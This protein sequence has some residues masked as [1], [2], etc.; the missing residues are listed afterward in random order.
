MKKLYTLFVAALIAAVSAM[1]GNMQTVRSISELPGRASVPASEKADIQKMR[2]SA[3]DINA[4]AVRNADIRPMADD[5]ETWKSIGT[6]TFVEGPMDLF[7]N[8]NA[9]DKWEIE[10][11]ESE[12]T[13]GRYRFIPYNA[14]SPLAAQVGSAD[15]NYMIVNA[16]DP[17][18]VYTETM[19]VYSYYD[20][21]QLV[22]EGGWS[23]YSVYGTLVDGC[24]SFPAQS[25]ALYNGGW[26]IANVSGKFKIFL[27]GAEVTDYSVTIDAELCA[28]NAYSFMATAGESAASLVCVAYSGYMSVAVAGDTDYLSSIL[29]YGSEIQSGVK[30][31]LENNSTCKTVIAM[32]LDADGNVQDADAVNIFMCADDQD[33]WRALDGTASFTETFV[34]GPYGEDVSAYDLAIEE[35]VNTPGYY[36]L[37]NPYQSHPIYG[38]YAVAHSG[39]NHY[40]YVNATDPEA[41]YVEANPLG[42]D[43][44]YQGEAFGSSDAYTYISMGYTIDEIKSSGSVALGTQS[45][46]T[47]TFPSYS[48]FSV[49]RNDNREY[50]NGSVCTIVLPASAGI[51]GINADI[52]AD[53]PAEYYNLQGV[54]V[55]AENLVPGFY[56]VRQGSKATKVWRTK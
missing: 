39:H 16:Q 12:Q 29:V 54:K 40:L 8:V 30:Y 20:I 52:D 33:N 22:P 50:Y 18:K 9:G 4:D 31:S 26:Y 25:H 48:L 1:A 2:I 42:V 21:T 14:N 7:S 55:A 45:G 13:A 32:T 44:Y 10:I 43:P 5:T 41:V 19:S 35:N 49:F 23:S 17:E 6:G 38:T 15:S 47:I 37:V 28:D 34:S 53:A 36:R 11:F 27:P 51:D 24:I 56:V 3:D 46:L